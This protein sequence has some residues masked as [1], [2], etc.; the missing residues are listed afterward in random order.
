MYLPCTLNEIKA[1]GWDAPDITLVS[2][3]AY[4]DSP[5]SGAALI[6]RVLEQQGFRVAIIAQPDVDNPADITRLGEPRLFWAVSSGCVDSMVANYTASG[7]KRRHDDFTPGGINNARPDR[8]IIVYCNLIRS[9]FKPCKP[10][11]IGGIEASLRRIAHYDWWSDKVRR[12][13]LFD[14]KAD[15]LVYGMAERTIIELA[16]AIKEGREWRSIRGLCY[17]QPS[18]KESPADA[19]LLPDFKC[20]AEKSGAGH[21]AFLQMFRIFTE[22]QE[23]QSARALVQSV[24]TRSLIHNPPAQILTTDELDSCHNLPF[25]LNVHPDCL[26][27]GAV[28][29]IDT[30]KFSITTHRGCYGSCNFCAIAMHQGRRVISRSENSIV[31][32]AKRMTEHP[33]FR[34]IISDAGGPTANMYGFECAHKIKHGACADKRCLYPA[35]CR[36]LQPTHQ[37]LINLLARLRAL[38]KVRK[39]FTAS[40]IR[41]D[42]VAADQRHG[43]EYIECIARDHVSGQLKLAPEHVNQRVLEFMGKPDNRSLLEFKRVFEESSRGLQLKQFLTYYFIAAHPGCSL[44]DMKELKRFATRELRLSPEQV[45]IF[46]PTPSTWS[47]AM[48]YTGIDP[49]S[50]QKIHVARGAR[51]KQM[52]KDV[53]QE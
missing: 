17:P 22:N 24:D 31:A 6:G 33:D 19:V 27:K 14:A 52:Q 44:E 10:I 34:G 4:I 45:Q 51:D 32:E 39:V 21:K 28:R 41:P 50:G 18:T 49:F 2:G 16:N 7:K 47:T 43:R 36:T 38:P 25:E 12:P 23:P 5:F 35:V 13:I 20:V 9:A 30:I 53:L 29:A 3:D 26:Q 40:G 1:R 15:I 37:P 46:T 8:A 42:L 48:Y 11:V